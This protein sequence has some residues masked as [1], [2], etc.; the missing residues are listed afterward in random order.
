MT[1]A[2]IR[3][4][5]W[6]RGS[7]RP[8][9]YT[10][11]AHMQAVCDQYVVHVGGN[12]FTATLGQRLSDAG[13]GKKDMEDVFFWGESA[14]WVIINLYDHQF[15][16][17]ISLPNIVEAFRVHIRLIGGVNGS[18][19]WDWMKNMSE[20]AK[21]HGALPIH[22]FAPA[23]AMARAKAD[24]RYMEKTVSHRKRLA[25]VPQAVSRP[26]QFGDWA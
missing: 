16:G 23:V 6:S 21:R 15:G 5:A 17:V 13:L 19:F 7:K 26:S 14:G 25:H 3:E 20:R 9:E 12:E 11:S 22:Q 10:P 8:A 4:L 18:E 2:E 1:A 24:W